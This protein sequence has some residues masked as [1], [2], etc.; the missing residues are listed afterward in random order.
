[1][2]YNFGSSHFNY[3]LI[4]V[5]DSLKFWLYGLVHSVIDVLPKAEHRACVIHIYVNWSKKHKGEELQLQF[6]NAAWSTFE[7]NS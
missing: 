7:E 6:W 5:M 3:L 4:Q 2:L 1:M